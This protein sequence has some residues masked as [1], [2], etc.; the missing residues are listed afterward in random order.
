MVPSTLE[1]GEMARLMERASS[2][3]QTVT[4][5]RVTG[6]ITRHVAMASTYTRTGINTR[7]SGMMMCSMA[8]VKS[9]GLMA[10]HTKGPIIRELNMA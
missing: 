1:S 5:M 10:A 6:V 8:M 7:V 3:I 4:I 2:S 9:D